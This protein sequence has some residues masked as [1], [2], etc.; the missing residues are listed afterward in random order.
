MLNAYGGAEWKQCRMKKR[1]SEE[2]TWNAFVSRAE[3][4]LSN[5]LLSGNEMVISLYLCQKHNHY[6]IDKRST[7]FLEL[8]QILQEQFAVARSLESAVR[9]AEEVARR[10]EIESVRG[11]EEVE[12]KVQEIV[13]AVARAKEESQ[14]VRFLQKTK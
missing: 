8:R 11:G 3:S 13:E 14:A 9:D 4:D 12:E 1:E 5:D 7:C 10:A 2:G 6:L